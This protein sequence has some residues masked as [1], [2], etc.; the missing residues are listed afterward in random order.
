MPQDS[1]TRFGSAQRFAQEAG[2]LLLQYYGR[3][4]GYERK[5][6]IDLVT[7]ADRASERLLV[8][9][10][11]AAFPMDAVLAEEGA[12]RDG[13]SGWEWVL[14]PLDGTTNFVHGFP[15]FVVSIGIRY[16]GTRHIGV[17]YGPVMDELYAAE[18]GGGATLN[19]APIHVSTAD[20][21]S[22]SLVA[23]GFPYNR[24]EIVETLLP[25]VERAVRTAQGIRRCG[26]AA[27]DQCLLAAGRLDGYFE[28]GL[29][30]WDVA[31][32]TVII[33]EA[34]GLVTDYQGAPFDLFGPS[35]LASN[36]RIHD[37]LRTRIVAG[38]TA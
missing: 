32:G 10:I 11:A 18:R 3:L 4:T 15:F 1:V 2:A 35:L 29:N 26:A 5:G 27:Y 36:G 6:A 13:D 20:C 21:L 22:D 31:A 17:C 8:S 24:R 25:K 12:G 14:D 19:G 7:D 37:E 30:P 28:Q 16:R 34:G 23:T 33:E 38:P 9:R